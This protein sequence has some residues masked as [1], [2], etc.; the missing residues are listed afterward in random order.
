MLPVL[1]MKDLAAGRFLSKWARVARN[2]FRRDPFPLL[3]LCGRVLGLDNS[4][5]VAYCAGL[6]TSNPSV[7][8]IDPS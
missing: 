3:G 6:L 4:V 5:L 2:E 1:N 7:V 8:G